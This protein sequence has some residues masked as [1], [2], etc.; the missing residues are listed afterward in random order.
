M[1]VLLEGLPVVGRHV[2]LGVDALAAHVNAAK[3]IPLTPLCEELVAKRFG[4]L[5]DD[6]FVKRECFTFKGFR[7]Q[8]CQELL[9]TQFIRQCAFS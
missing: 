2:H 9:S 3:A 5:N 4:I 6:I 7:F 1:E 8:F